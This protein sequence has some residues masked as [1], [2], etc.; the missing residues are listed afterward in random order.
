MGMKDVLQARYMLLGMGFF[1]MYNG[2]LYN[3]YFAIPNDWFG[4]CFDTSTR[5]CLSTSTDCNPTYF[6]KSPYAE[7]E[8]KEFDCVYPFGV[9]PAWYLSPQLL[10][11]TNNI[12]MKIAVIIGIA[13]MSMG[14]CV[15][16]FNA[17]YFGHYDTLVFEVI[18]GLIIMLGLFG[19]MDFLIFAKWTYP[20]EAY[21]TDEFQIKR[22][23]GAQS[24]I[25]VM[26]NNFLALGN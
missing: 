10:T 25:T 7:G 8:E 21:S 14:V 3:E 17:V 12:K 2:L 9:D 15:K 1:A 26:I 18:A 19:W 4:S 6:Y 16:G 5:A 24:I 13:H 22:I 23:Q 11:F 20:M